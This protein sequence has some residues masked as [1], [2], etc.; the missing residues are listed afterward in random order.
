MLNLKSE[1]E[2]KYHALVR[3]IKDTS[4][5][6]PC[7]TDPDKWDGWDADGVPIPTEKEAQSWCAGCPV[8]NLCADYA[9]TE[10]PALGVY[11]GKI[12]GAQMVQAERAGLFD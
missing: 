6:V 11:A 7:T 5:E 8:R 9:E 2:P 1:S 12:Y 4:V 10:R 3:A